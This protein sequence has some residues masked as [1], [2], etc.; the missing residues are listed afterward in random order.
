MASIVAE[1]ADFSEEVNMIVPKN[2]QLNP[3]DLAIY[4]L[5]DDNQLCCKS[6]LDEK[7]KLIG[8]NAL[9]A[10]SDIIGSDFRKLQQLY[11]KHLKK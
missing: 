1:D 7:T 11:L 5:S 4:A 9:D 8:M 6:L 3:N 2:E 10:V